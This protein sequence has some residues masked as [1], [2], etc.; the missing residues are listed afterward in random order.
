MIQQFLNN[1]NKNSE[2]SFKQSQIIQQ[3]NFGKIPCQFNHGS[4]IKCLIFDVT[5]ERQATYFCEN[6]LLCKFY[7]KIQNLWI[8]QKDRNKNNRW[9]IQDYKLIIP[10]HSLYISYINL[11]KIQ[12]CEN[13]NLRFSMCKKMKFNVEL[14]VKYLHLNLEKYKL[15]ELIR[16]QAKIL[17][18]NQT[19][20]Q[21][22]DQ[23]IHQFLD[24]NL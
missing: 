16:L 15:K 5:K 8:K 11:N 6:A 10:N 13:N 17:N 4:P 14:E 9:N 18:Y 19:F 12:R 20:N 22:R 1:N 24:L 21:K 23:K 7:L 2:Q 3:K